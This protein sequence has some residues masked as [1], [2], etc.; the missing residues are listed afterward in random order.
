MIYSGVSCFFWECRQLRSTLFS[1]CLTHENHTNFLM[2]LGDVPTSGHLTNFTSGVRVSDPGHRENWTKSMCTSFGEE[3]KLIFL[4][5]AINNISQTIMHSPLT[6]FVPN[7]PCILW[8]QLNQCLS[9][10]LFYCISI[11]HFH[12]NASFKL[13]RVNSG[14][15]YRPCLLWQ[16]DV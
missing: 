7:S 15:L 5:S 10:E 13:L 9:A 16:S 2:S 6:Q 3:W 12:S 8:K 4:Q 14:H 1:E 11:L